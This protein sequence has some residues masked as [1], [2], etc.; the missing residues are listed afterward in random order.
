MKH[1]LASVWRLTEAE[2]LIAV[3][4]TA[5]GPAPLFTEVSGEITAV[6]YTDVAEARADL[7]DTHRLFSIQ[8]AEFLRQL[9]GHVGLVVDP[10]SPSPVHVAADQ[11]PDVL[12]AA[13][14][15]PAGVPV[16]IGEPAK[17]PKHLVKA[18]RTSAPALPVLRRLWRIWYQKADADGRLL[19]VYDV[20][21][22][23]GADKAAADLVVAAAEQVDY[24]DKLLVL[25]LDDLPSEHREWLLA[26]TRPA[27]ERD[28]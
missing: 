2:V 5:D 8:V 26:N 22:T 17:Q 16:A 10:R 18:L 9:P 19:V 20:D 23:E 27:Y 15:F 13:R 14:P 21:G 6:A 1:S 25:A 28:P 12:D 3:A 4:Q 24:A 11:R 7:P